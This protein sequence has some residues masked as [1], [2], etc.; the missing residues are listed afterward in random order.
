MKNYLSYLIIAVVAI[1]FSFHLFEGKETPAMI[2]NI[3]IIGLF[4]EN[5]NKG[6]D[7][8][9]FLLLMVVGGVLLFS[10]VWFQAV[11]GAILIGTG[12]IYNLVYEKMNQDK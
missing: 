12:A 9:L 10:D 2:L 5:F 3:V 6:I 4:W 7:K 8:N 11:S 1:V